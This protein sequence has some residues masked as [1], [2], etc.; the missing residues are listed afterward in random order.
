MHFHGL[1]KRYKKIKIPIKG[2][3][4]TLAIADTPIKKKIGLSQLGKLPNLC[5][6]IFTYSTPVDHTFTMEKTSIPLTILF[7]DKNFSILEIFTCRPF[8]KK[9]IQPSHFYSYVIEI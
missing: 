5:G 6:M 9:K 8:S 4:Y 7:L 1:F 2:K 3:S